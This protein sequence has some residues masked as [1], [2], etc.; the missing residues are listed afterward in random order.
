MNSKKLLCYSIL[1]LTLLCSCQ[2]NQLEDLENTEGSKL[3]NV[4]TIYNCEDYIDETLIEAFE[5][6]YDV[7]VNYYTYDTNE[8]LY[9][10]LTLQPEGTYDLVCPSEYMIQRLVSEDLINQLDKSKLTTYYENASNEILSKIASMP[11][12]K[13][14]ANGK[15]LCLD[16]YAAGY[17]WGTMGLIYDPNCISEEDIKTWDVLWNDK[18]ENYASVKNSMRDTYVV[19]IMH[20][21]QEELKEA[22]NKYLSSEIDAEKYNSKIQDVFNRHDDKDIA[23]VKQELIDLKKNIYGFENDS[24]KN[25]ITTGKIKINLA[26]SGD[27]VYSISTA[28]DEAN[29]ELK[30]C[31]PDEGSNIWYDGWVMPKG[32]NEDLAYK[33]INFLSDPVNAA[34][35]MEYIGYTSFIA[36]NEVFDNVTN[37]YGASDYYKETEYYAANE[38]EETSASVV[39][40]E[41]K[42]YEC[43][44][45]AKGIIP[46]NE[47]YFTLLDEENSPLNEG[48]DLSYYFKDT[49]PSDKS[50]F[51]YP[52]EECANRLYT[53][54]PDKE[55][56]N[57]CA[58]MNDF[59]EDNAKVII[60][61]SQVKAS[62]DM[63]PYYTILILVVLF[64]PCYFL[65]KLLRDKAIE[66]YASKRNN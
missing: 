27:A 58:F 11:T 37:W 19:G 3:D 21:Y 51:I 59:G 56:I 34:I 5:E 38:D 61:W 50:L 8:T 14:D 35:N 4:L 32:A 1:T 44:K 57:R 29:K 55:T 54:Y 6:E 25:D 30:Y 20:A 23:L 53:Q 43:I 64:V 31:V 46:T 16:S 9:N 13:K 62:T 41:N 63:V 28:Y 10:Q 40:F 47:E 45:D 42:F 52:F 24:G 65:V 39:R 66:Y 22:R 26:W 12:S 49:A 15:T 18:Y 48:Y 2:N 17:M 36:S 60:M 33:F 7:T